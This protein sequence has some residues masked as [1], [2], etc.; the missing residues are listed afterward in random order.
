[1]LSITRLPLPYLSQMD[2][3][4]TL[5]VKNLAAW[6]SGRALRRGASRT[7]TRIT[8][9]VHTLPCD[10]SYL[11]VTLVRIFPLVL[12]DL[13]FAS[14]RADENQRFDVAVWGQIPQ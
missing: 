6:A 14:R 10:K 8:L 7:L 3:T 5:H 9:C 4:Y 12:L 11:S 2:G 1:M 13:P